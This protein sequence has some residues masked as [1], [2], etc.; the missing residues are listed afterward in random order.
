MIHIT[1]NTPGMV[2]IDFDPLD[3]SAGEVGGT[4]LVNYLAQYGV[5]MTNVTVGTALEAVNTN[6]LTG[7]IQVDVPSSPNFFTQAGLNQPVS[8]TL[9]FATPWQSF[10]FTRVG[11]SASSGPVSHPQWTATIFDTNGTELGLVFRAFACDSRPVAARSFVL[12]GANIASVRFD[13]DSQGI[14]AFSAVLLDNLVLNYNPAALGLS[15]ALAVVSP[16]ANDIVAPATIVLGANVMDALSSSYSVSFFAGPALLGTASNSPF[17]ITL[18]NV[19]PGNYSLQARVTDAS[20]LAVPSKVVSISVQPA[21]N[22]TVVNFDSLNAATGAVTDGLLSSYLAGFGITVATN[23]SAGTTLAVENQAAIHGGGAVAASSPPNILTQIGFSGPVS[24]TVNFATW[25]TNFGFTRPELL[26]NPFV[27]HP[28]WQAT[29][30]DAAGVVL[31]QVGEGLIGSYTNVGA[32]AFNLSGPGIASVQFASQGSGLTT[33]NAMLADDFVLTTNAA[34][35][36]FPPAVA[37]TS[38]PTGLQLVSPVTL[39]LTAQAASP[40]G[41][42]S[43]IFYANGASIGT[44]TSSPYAVPWVNPGVG[45]YALTA[46]ALDKNGL[47][48][49]SPVVNVTVLPS[50]FVFGILT[51]PVS[52]TA[53]VGSSVTFSVVTTGT[54]AVTY[55]WYQNGAILAGQTASTLTLFPVN[56]ADREAT[57]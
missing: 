53:K 32:Q 12:E 46:V 4:A 3:T 49:T 11:L 25:L 44:N 1:V 52:Q 45:G 30:F 33:F 26:A 51:P 6:S 56:A 34:G 35:V 31:G 21:P 16:P 28:A 22:S 48:R 7:T 38:P 27:S 8:F 17:Q 29:A 50:A 20:G 14:A 36:R 43:V 55:Q 42:V 15:V 23:I 24:Y 5:G 9:R 54:G 40:A 47:S 2:L 39:T 57:R 19:L 37:I 18:T 13:S 41:I 10:G